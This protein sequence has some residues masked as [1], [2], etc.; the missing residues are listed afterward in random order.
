MTMRTRKRGVDYVQKR[1]YESVK[2]QI[3]LTPSVLRVADKVEKAAETSMLRGALS[4]HRLHDMTEA[5]NARKKRKQ[6]NGKVVQKYG[7]IYKYQAVYDIE[8]EEEEE[9]RVVNMRHKRLRK[10]WE[11]KYQKVIQEINRSVSLVQ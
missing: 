1:Q 8:K 2:N 10:Q 6:Q 9:S 3:P 4:T 5:E 7:E 11:K